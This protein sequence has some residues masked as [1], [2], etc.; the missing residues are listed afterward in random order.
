MQGPLGKTWN[1]VRLHLRS[2]PVCF[3]Y[4]HMALIHYLN[5]FGIEGMEDKEEKGKD[6]VSLNLLS[7]TPGLPVVLL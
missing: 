6:T 1:S 3:C 2:S 5:H 4:C 7:P